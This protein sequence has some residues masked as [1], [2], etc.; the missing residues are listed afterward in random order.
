MEAIK[1]ELNHSDV[2]AATD[3]S[4]G[5]GATTS[6]HANALPHF[7]LPAAFAFHI[8]PRTEHASR[9]FQAPAIRRID[10]FAQLTPA[11]C[12]TERIPVCGALWES[13]SAPLIPL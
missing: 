2:T 1:Y 9:P 11:G 12:P 4:S 7:A 5:H 13:G 6:S 8:R 10:D 3:H